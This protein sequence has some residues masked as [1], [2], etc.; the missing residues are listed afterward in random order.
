MNMK[1][2][3]VDDA[4][5]LESLEFALKDLFLTNISYLIIGAKNLIQSLIQKI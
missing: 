2:N 5:T 3:F 1:V 4:Q